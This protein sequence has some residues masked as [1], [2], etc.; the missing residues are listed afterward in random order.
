M[1]LYSNLVSGYL[2]VTEYLLCVIS[3]IKQSKNDITNLHETIADLNINMTKQHKLG[4]VY[5]V[6]K[7]ACLQVSL[8]MNPIPAS[9]KE[10]RLN[11]FLFFLYS[12]RFTK[13]CFEP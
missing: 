13:K 8:F 9:Y 4:N 11:A 7:T 5:Q 1:A 2:K 10:L 12:A 6:N 3:T